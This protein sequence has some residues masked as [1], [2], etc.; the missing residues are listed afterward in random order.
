MT[1]KTI[2]EKYK[3]LKKK[4]YCVFVDLRKAFDTVPRQALLFKLAYMGI[5]GKIFNVI[6]DMYSSSTMQLKLGNKLSDKVRTE[7]GTEQGHTLSPEFFKCY[8]DDLSPFLDHP[9]V[10]EL[11]RLLISHLLWAD[12]LVLMGLSLKSAQHLLNAFKVFCDTW[13]L[14][15]NSSKTS[16]VIFNKR[17]LIN[18]TEFVF[19]GDS[20][21]ETVES[22]TYLGLK[23]HM[24][25]SMNFAIRDLYDKAIRA[26]CAL[27]RY[28]NRTQVSIKGLTRLFDSLISPI[29][30]YGAAIW[31]PYLNVIK[32]VTEYTEV[33]RGVD[34]D[35]R[36]KI[37]ATLHR[38]LSSQMAEKLHLKYIKWCLGVHKLSSNTAC[39]NEIGR[40]PLLGS[41]MKQTLSYVDRLQALPESMLV[42]RAFIEQ[43]ELSLPWYISTQ[44]MVTYSNGEPI[45][46]KFEDTFGEIWSVH[47]QNQSKLSFYSTLCRRYNSEPEK[48][49]STV[50]NFK[51]R[52]NITKIR[53]SAHRLAIEAGRYRKQAREERI[54]PLCDNNTV[55][56]ERHF[57]LWCPVLADERSIIFN[58]LIKNKYMELNS[59]PAQMNTAWILCNATSADNDST[60]NPMSQKAVRLSAR[61]IHTM[62]SKRMENSE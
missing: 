26:T 24:S 18:N 48:Y 50:K 17:S 37:C 13:G 35:T 61:V 38:K 10:P 32:S 7:K 52:S 31:A 15:I 12:D 1:I 55:E 5:T 49:L 51:H 54:C 58:E 57:L 8:L 47:L 29:L 60:K 25:G 28:L 22:Y 21:L 53:V 44:R 56:D 41:L 4:V 16:M 23:L 34:I 6:R 2:I 62:Y 42:K 33:T 40:P 36:S 14:E 3:K 27:K 11:N 46:K 39:W 19:L 9:D 20:A 43:K 30:M 59:V 45:R